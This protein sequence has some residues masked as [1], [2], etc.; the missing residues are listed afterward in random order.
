MNC[1]PLCLLTPSPEPIRVVQLP[2]MFRRANPR[3]ATRTCMLKAFACSNTRKRSDKVAAAAGETVTS[4]V[5]FLEVRGCGGESRPQS[6]GHPVS[7]ETFP[8]IL[9]SA[10]TEGLGKRRAMRHN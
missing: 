4:L 6:R 1:L 2:E 9:Q 10:G 8:S 7:N 3:A 5:F